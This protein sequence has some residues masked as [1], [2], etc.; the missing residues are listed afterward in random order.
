MNIEPMMGNIVASN[1]LRLITNNK[2]KKRL[3]PN[4]RSNNN[5]LL[6]ITSINSQNRK[7]LKKK[8]KDKLMKQLKN[9][10]K[11]DLSQRDSIL[12]NSINNMLKQ[13]SI[14]TKNSK[15]RVMPSSHKSLAKMKVTSTLIVITLG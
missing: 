6:I 7:E 2:L 15:K 8:G 9:K 13:T 11:P 5:K 3:Q 4:N 14:M 12:P 1:N 10:D